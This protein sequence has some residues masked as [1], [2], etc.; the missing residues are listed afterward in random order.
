MMNWLYRFSLYQRIQFSLILFIL[1]PISIVSITSYMTTKKTMLERIE[2][3]NKNLVRA[4]SHDIERTI[5]DIAYSSVF[6][7]RINEL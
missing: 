2:A 6:F 5:E 1:L 7:T 3:T 4:I